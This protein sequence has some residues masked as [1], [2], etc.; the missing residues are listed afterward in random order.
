MIAPG[1]LQGHVGTKLRGGAV[2]GAIRAQR[3]QVGKDDAMNGRGVCE[4]EGARN[5][6][7]ETTG[8][9]LRGDDLH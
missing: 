8:R 7:R 2:G 5:A 3:L 6:T 4:V 9:P 1:G